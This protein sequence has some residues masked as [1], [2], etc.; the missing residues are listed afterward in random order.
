M[1]H[2]LMIESFLE[3]NAVIL[4]RLLNT[5]EQLDAFSAYIMFLTPPQGGGL[6][7][8]E[9]VETLKADSNIIYSEV[10]NCIKLTWE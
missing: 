8:M 7:N 2:L 1:A 4:P 9:G 5:Y 3:G 6:V 10:K